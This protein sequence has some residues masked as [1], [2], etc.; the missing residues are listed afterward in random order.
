MVKNFELNK[1]SN[2]NK[3]NLYNKLLNGKLTA[4][5]VCVYYENRH[6]LFDVDFMHNDLCL[7]SWTYNYYI[8]TPK[9]IK[10]ERYNSFNQAINALKKVVNKEGITFNQLFVYKAG[11]DYSMK[12]LY[13][14]DL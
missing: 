8:R 1:L 14:I 6:Y 7:N 13:T 5:S 2:Q 3:E 11:K 10:S 12:H 4:Q 9:A